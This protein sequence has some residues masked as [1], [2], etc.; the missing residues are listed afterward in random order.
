MN[1]G[2]NSATRYGNVALGVESALPAA[3]LPVRCRP[4][5]RLQRLCSRLLATLR[6][7]A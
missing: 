5:S 4:R 7:W 1:C 3:T 6:R 2:M